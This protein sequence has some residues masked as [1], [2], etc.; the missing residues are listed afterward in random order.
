MRTVLQSC[1]LRIETG[2]FVYLVGPSGCGKST[3]LKLLY[4]DHLPDEGDIWVGDFYLNDIKP[5]EIPLLRRSMG[6]VFQ[7]FKL[8][9]DRRVADNVAFTLHAQEASGAVVKRKTLEALTKVGLAYK[10]KAMP[11]EISGGEQQ[12]I[13]IARAI[14]HDPWLLLADEPT[15]NLDPDV[16]ENI[17]ELLLSLNQQGMTILMATHNYDLVK[18]YPSKTLAILDGHLVEVDVTR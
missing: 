17:M 14:V 16:A 18:K 1:S 12:R 7:D 5:T 11:H 15:G 4:R 6:I 13:C 2:E 3:L 9:T 8:L 10:R